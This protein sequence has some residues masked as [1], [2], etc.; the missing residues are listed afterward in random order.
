MCVNIGSFQ[1]KSAAQATAA[2]DEQP[3]AEGEERIC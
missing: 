2:R 3:F 1:G